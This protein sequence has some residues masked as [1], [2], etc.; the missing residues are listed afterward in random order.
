M[1]P[2]A[3]AEAKQNK[4]VKQAQEAQEAPPSLF[5]LPFFPPQEAAA[6]IAGDV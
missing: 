3:D 1:E 2:E 6:T 4:K 5:F